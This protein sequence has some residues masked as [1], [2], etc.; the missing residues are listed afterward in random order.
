MAVREL[1]SNT[2]DEAGN[3]FIIE[4]TGKE[5]SLFLR[6]HG[7]IGEGRTVIVI[8]CPEMEEAYLN[9]EIFLPPEKEL[10]LEIGPLSIYDGPSNYIF[11][12]GLR[13]TDLNKPSLY[14]YDFNLGVTLTEDRTSKWPYSDGC[15]IMEAIM[16]TA[17]QDII[18]KVLDADEDAFYEGSLPFDQPHIAPSTPFFASM[19]YRANTDGGVLP[20]RVRTM[21][22]NLTTV[23]E[24]KEQ[25][26][27]SLTEKQ[28]RWLIENIDQDDIIEACKEALSE[29]DIPF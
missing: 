1:E 10:V 17:N 14:T 7:H 21:Y 8:D 12:R 23:E 24:R 19:G 11:F 13:V 2:R 6:E 4:D 15:R 18:D 22:R 20:K 25:I 5:V 28:I 9:E 26:D 16:A 27:V 3:S 29:E